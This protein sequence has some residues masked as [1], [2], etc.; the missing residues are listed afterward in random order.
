MNS[1]MRQHVGLAF[2]SG[3]SMAAHRGKEK[4]F[5]SLL[6]PKIHHG[7]HDGRDIRD[8]AAANSDG[9]AATLRHAR[10]EIRLPE[11]AADMLANVRNG[12]VKERLFGK[13]ELGEVHSSSILLGQRLSDVGLFAPALLEHKRIL[14]GG[15]QIEGELILL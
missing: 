13:D 10:D 9:D 7:F 4:W 1:V 14:P 15:V 2:G 11:F 12:A 5:K 6:L 3:R 8:A